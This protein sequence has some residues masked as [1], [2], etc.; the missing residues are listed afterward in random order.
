MDAR[1]GA[2][3]ADLG[4]ITDGATVDVS[5][6]GGWASIRADVA[7]PDL[8]GSIRIELSGKLSLSRLENAP[9]PF[10]LFGDNLAG[11]YYAVRLM[12]G[13]YRV[14]ATPYSDPDA[15]GALLAAHEVA[16]TVTDARVE[17]AITGFTLIDASG[18]CRGEREL[19]PVADG[20]AVDVSRAAGRVDIRAD[21][22][23]SAGSVRLVLS[24]PRSLVRLTDVPPFSLFGVGRKRGHH[25]A[26]W[27]TDG[28]YTLTATVFAGHEASGAE[29]ASAH[30][31]VHG[32]GR[33]RGRSRHRSRSSTRAAGRRTRTSDRWRTA[34]PSTCPPSGAWSASVPI[35][36][37]GRRPGVRVSPCRER[38]TS[39]VL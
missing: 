38:A 22:T 21:V 26:G 35:C 33:R 15:G 6:I 18:R 24:G 3:D 31:R 39:S 30:G 8:V 25:R 14:K 11:D 28:A 36:R 29:L 37:P 17:P 32:V 34:R 16:F 5:G 7:N 20:G 19:G 12:P 4:P 13:S 27:L 23:G 9:T 10:A 2:P 1:G